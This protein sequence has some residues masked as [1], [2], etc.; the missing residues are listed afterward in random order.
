MFVRENEVD[1]TPKEFELLYFMASNAQCV[2]SRLQLLDGLWDLAYD[3]D[4][5]TV[6][7]HIRR[8]RRKIE[9]NPSTPRWLR[10][11]RFAVTLPE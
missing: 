2:F 11:A 4:P 6:T 8:L 7:V 1:L 5:S 3:G 10:G 9:T